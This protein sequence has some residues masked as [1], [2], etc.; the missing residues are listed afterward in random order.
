MRPDIV[1]GNTFPDYEHQII[2]AQAV[3]IQAPDVEHLIPMVEKVV[4]NCEAIPDKW[5]ADAGYFSEQ[6]LV[7]IVKWKIDPHIA[8]GRRQHDAPPPS[9]RGRPPASLMI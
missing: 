4:E 5:S 3:T 7:E 6:N 1:P 2:I 9:V 8:T